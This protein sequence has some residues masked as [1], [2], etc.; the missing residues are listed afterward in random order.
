MIKLDIEKIQMPIEKAKEEW[1]RYNDLLK[2]RR[3]SYIEQMKKCMFHLKQGRELIDIYKVMEHI[4]VNKEQQ[5][6]L[7]IARADWD[8]VYFI[9]KDEGRGFFVDGETDW[10]LS[11][12]GHVSLPPKT[13]MNWARTHEQRRTSD[14]KNVSVETW[15]IAKEKIKTKV[16]VIPAVMMPEGDLSQYY[17]LWEVKQWEELP[18]T[19]DPLLLRRIT[20]NLFVILGAWDITP[21]EQSIINNDW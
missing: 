19:K 1:K 4:G 6:R 18:E 8:W 11:S 21:L 9:K 7:A 3:E 20:E 5:P 14:N 2:K 16:P 15:H 12:K 17:I 10:Y 13:F